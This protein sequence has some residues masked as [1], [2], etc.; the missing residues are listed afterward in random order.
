[1]MALEASVEVPSFPE[2]HSAGGLRGSGRRI[3][4]GIGMIP[5]EWWLTPIQHR[6]EV[7]GRAQ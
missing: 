5:E 6:L 2:R 4:P 1:M 3:G 7:D